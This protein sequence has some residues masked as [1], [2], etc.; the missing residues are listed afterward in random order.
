M[1]ITK[2]LDVCIHVFTA[3][4]VLQ[5]YRISSETVSPSRQIFAAI[6]D[7]AVGASYTV[8]LFTG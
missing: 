5:K 2:R 8:P 1:R 6:T 7:S 3:T 4:A